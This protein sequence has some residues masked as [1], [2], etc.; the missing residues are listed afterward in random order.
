MWNFL[1]HMSGSRTVRSLADTMRCYFANT[2]SAAVPDGLGDEAA[3]R[4]VW[5][6]DVR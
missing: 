1:L 5:Q 2:P 3:I 6:A 4:A